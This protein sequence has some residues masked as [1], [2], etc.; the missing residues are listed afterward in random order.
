MILTGRFGVH[1]KMM[2]GLSILQTGVS[3]A[4]LARASS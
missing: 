2:T 1:R 3:A 4:A